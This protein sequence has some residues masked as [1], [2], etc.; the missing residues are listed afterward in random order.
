MTIDWGCGPARNGR[1]LVTPKI[2]GSNPFIPASLIM[3]KLIVV[4]SLNPQKIDAVFQAVKDTAYGELP[5]RRV[6]GFAASSGVPEQ[7]IGMDSIV[8]GAHNRARLALKEHPDS[9][10][11]GIESGVFLQKLHPTQESHRLFDVCVCTILA[12]GGNQAVG[13]SSAWALPSDVSDLIIHGNGEVTMDDALVQTG[14]TKN[15][16]LGYS[17]GGI[18][19]LSDGRINRKSYTMQAVVAALI[20]WASDAVI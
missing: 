3:E 15:P 14:R 6:V 18:D 7:P 19:L 4:G 2:E 13:F 1:R 17:A 5:T 8:S 20:D 11:F 16:R 12:K 10:A 9:I